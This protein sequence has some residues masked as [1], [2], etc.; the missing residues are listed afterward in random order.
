VQS[1]VN[2]V[3]WSLACELFFYLCF[4]YL[5]RLIALIRP[6]RL[7]YWAGG[8][9]AAI[10]LV[11]FLV[12][13][14]TPAE[15]KGPPFQTTLLQTWLTYN[16]P[17][18]RLLEFVLGILLARIVITGRWYPKRFHYAL[19]AIPLGY[20]AAL[21]FVFPYLVMAILVVPV[22]LLVLAA[23][24]ADITGS[25]G[26]RRRS[27]IWLGD[28]SFAF[29]MTHVLVILYLHRLLDPEGD[30]GVAADIG[31]TAAYLAI[32]VLVSWL[33]YRAVERP[34]MRRWGS[35]RGRPTAAP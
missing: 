8:L 22:A 34:A 15:P 28:I 33:L 18:I 2:P 23:A 30:A 5:H 6:E 16:F 12:M 27:W 20:L 4:P 9:F 10:A 29:Y 14:L 35:S 1:G 19:I 13:A 31:Y 17:P 25:P 32:S 24:H 3:S 7:W 21:Q 11:P 26:L